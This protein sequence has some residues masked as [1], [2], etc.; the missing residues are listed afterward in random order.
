MRDGFPLS[1]CI[2][3]AL[4]LLLFLS[5]GPLLISTG[6]THNN[7]TH[8]QHSASI[9]VAGTRCISISCVFYCM[10]AACS[11]AAGQEETRHLFPCLPGS[12]YCAVH[13]LNRP[14]YAYRTRGK[15]WRTTAISR[16]CRLSSATAYSTVVAFF[17][18]SNAANTPKSCSFDAHPMM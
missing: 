6:T 9:F 15:R 18:F 12:I 11:C 13:R 2:L 14:F 3:L 7:T 4:L 5:C 17:F 10:L 16:M 8:E 1:T